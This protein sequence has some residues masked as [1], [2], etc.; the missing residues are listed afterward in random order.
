MDT[1][2]LE[3]LTRE[4]LNKITGLG[5]PG[6]FELHHSGL[7]DRVRDN[8]LHANESDVW[9]V[10]RRR[11]QHVHEI[12]DALTPN[13]TA[14]RTLAHDLLPLAHTVELSEFDKYPKLYDQWVNTDLADLSNTSAFTVLG[15][16]VYL[17]YTHATTRLVEW[18]VESQDEIAADAENQ[19]MVQAV[20]DACAVITFG[21]IK[22][23]YT[24]GDL[25]HGV[26]FVDSREQRVWLGETGARE[27]AMYYAHA[28]HDYASRA[29]STS[30]PDLPEEI[31]TVLTWDAET[32]DE[33][34]ACDDG[35]Y[36]G[37]YIYKQH[38]DPET[39]Y[40]L[41][42]LASLPTLED[43]GF[44]ELK[45]RTATTQVWLSKQA[46]MGPEGESFT[47]GNV[48]TIQ[49][50]ANGEEINKTVRPARN[51]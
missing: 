24:G 13:Q 50:F 2:K 27:A 48:V 33:R 40:R 18:L 36:T 46:R 5:I 26:R 47:R 10:P 44:T 41:R 11:G 14:T 23:G 51:D 42:H 25:G 1:S 17:A 19:D 21:E 4:Q 15:R 45:I 38:A 30:T 22:L 16:R 8:V 3:V 35:A 43:D 12:A 49:E 31:A 7:I 6:E 20:S 9:D 29:Q 28:A 34:R 37:E 39:R 32:D